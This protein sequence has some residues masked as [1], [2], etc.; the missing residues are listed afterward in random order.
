MRKCERCDKP[1]ANR[2]MCNRCVK[3]TAKPISPRKRDAD[4]YIID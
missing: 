3:N 4:G 2:G 1:T